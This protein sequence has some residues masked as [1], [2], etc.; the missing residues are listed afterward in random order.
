MLK[1]QKGRAR[2]WNKGNNGV[3][4]LALNIHL[5]VI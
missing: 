4:L 5:F 2:I 1:I 3:V